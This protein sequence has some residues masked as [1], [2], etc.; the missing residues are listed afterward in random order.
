VVIVD[1]GL[2][3]LLE[4]QGH[5]ISTQLWSAR[6][7]STNPEAIKRAHVA[8][9][10]AGADVIISATYQATAEGFVR[11]GF[12]PEEARQVIRQGAALAVE[13]RDEWWE[14]IGGAWASERETSNNL[15]ARGR[16]GDANTRLRQRP[17]VAASVGSYGAICSRPE[18]FHL[19]ACRSR[20]VFG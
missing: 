12:S 19:T 9:L 20:G 7:I 4:S 10:D 6:L 15:T 13:A 5:D 3:T 14:S 8:Y 1:G 18:S 17:L 2:A 11:A 16:V